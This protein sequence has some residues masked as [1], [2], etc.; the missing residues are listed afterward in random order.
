MSMQAASEGSSDVEVRAL[1]EADL[2]EIVRIDAQ[3]FGR[4]RPEYYAL[5]VKRSLEDTGVRMSLIAEAEGRVVGFLM[6]SVY[7]GDF[8]QPEPTATL[9]AI[10][11]L[12]GYARR[13]VATSLWRQ[14]ES[15]AK[16]LRIQR[17]ETQVD[18]QSWDLLAFLHG[19]GFRPSRRLCLERPLDIEKD[20]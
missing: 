6:G 5:K 11:V 1:R 9:E 10:G 2:S 7:Y 19:M 16:A 17:I 18:W 12:L 15:N 20:D 14:F 8:G 3:R 13:G 4:P